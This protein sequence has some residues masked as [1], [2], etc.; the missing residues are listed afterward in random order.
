MTMKDKAMTLVIA[1]IFVN[2]AANLFVASGLA[3]DFGHTPAIGGDETIDR[4]SDEMQSVE[5]TGG[6]AA[7]LFQLYTS[8][9]GPVKWVVEILFGAELMLYNMQAPNW[10]INFLLA[11]KGIIG[12]A[13]IIYTLTGR[14]L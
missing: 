1:L 14:D 7:T 2:A 12:G 11:P 5:P 3:E 6:F 9:T 8:V 13:A 10:L 4:A